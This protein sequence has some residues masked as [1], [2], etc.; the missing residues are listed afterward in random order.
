MSHKRLLNPSS[1]MLLPAPFLRRALG[2]SNSSWQHDLSQ[3][4]H[5]GP[6]RGFGARHIWAEHPDEM[7]GAG[8]ASEEFVPHFVAQ[9]IKAGTP[10]YFEGHFSAKTRLIAVV[11]C[12][13][14]DPRTAV[15]R[16]RSLS[17]P[18][19]PPI[20]QTKSTVSA[21]EPCFDCVV[22]VAASP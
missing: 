4:R 21:S 12:A 18:S 20:G 1:G 10:L 5:I 14:G 15:S 13:S 19:S 22:A 8:F 3:G 2:A 16:G 17:G 7:R 6:N 11:A 9:I